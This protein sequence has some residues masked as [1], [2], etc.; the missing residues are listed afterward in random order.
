MI[1]NEADPEIKAPTFNEAAFVEGISMD[2][3]LD[4][5]FIFHVQGLLNDSRRRSPIFM[6]LQASCASFDDVHH[7]SSAGIVTLPGESEI[8]R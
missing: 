1:N 4:I 6:K 7:R 5:V 2:V 8:H 3:D